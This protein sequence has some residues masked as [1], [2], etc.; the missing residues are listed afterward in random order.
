LIDG[1]SSQSAS[2]G[3]ILGASLLGG[4]TSTTQ[5]VASSV[6]GVGLGRK[7]LRHVHWLI[8][9]E[10]GLAWLITIPLTALLAAGLYGVEQWLA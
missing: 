4:P 5:V 10:M 3:V 2:A 6:V 7:R 1:L 9:R 8:V